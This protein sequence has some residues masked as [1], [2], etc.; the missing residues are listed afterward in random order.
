MESGSGYQ[1]ALTTPPV[2]VCEALTMIFLVLKRGKRARTA[3]RI[4]SSNS[5]GIVT[6]SHITHT[7]VFWGDRDSNT[8]TLASSGVSIFEATRRAICPSSDTGS[9]GVMSTVVAPTLNSSAAANEAKR[10]RTAPRQK[11]L[12]VKGFITAL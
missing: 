2:C 7:L 4:R 5:V 11:F 8:K 10:H 3:L 1:L 6:I 12:K 9:W